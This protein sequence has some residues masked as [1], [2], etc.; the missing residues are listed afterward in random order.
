MAAMVASARDLIRS[1][2]CVAIF[3]AMRNKDY[4]SMAA[5]LRELTKDIV[6]TAPAVER[7]TP[8]EDLARLFDPPALVAPDVASAL[9]Q[10]HRLAGPGGVVVICGSLY[11]AGE[12]LGLLGR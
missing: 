1:H 2:R 8:P 7:A 11:L 6:V 5:R 4:V 3:A 10:A 12:A 9:D